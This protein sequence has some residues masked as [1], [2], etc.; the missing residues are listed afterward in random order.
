M[1]R[2]DAAQLLP[3]LPS[4]C[5]DA[6][7][8]DPPWNLGRPYG[9]TTDR[10][11]DD[12]Y[13]RW[14][15][16]ILRECARVSRGAVAVCI[17]THNAARTDRL[18]GGSGLR[19]AGRLCWHREPGCRETVLLAAPPGWVPPAGR[20]AAAARVLERTPELRRR[21]GHPVPKPVP[22]MAALVRLACPPGGLLLDPF[23]GTG[24]TLVAARR[25]GRRSIGLELE[26]RF[27]RTAVA[28]LATCGV[29][30]AA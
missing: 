7:V 16:G 27:C 5:V 23:V 20:L 3:A 21:F 19:V 14:L 28:R 18:L 17:G 8:T 11:A 6:V 13:V 24:S 1:V 4:G 25:A 22:V 9:T 10:M 15:A 12:D 2:A 26:E 29:R 30:R